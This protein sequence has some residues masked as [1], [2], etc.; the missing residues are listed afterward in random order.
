MNRSPRKTGISGD[1]GLFFCMRPMLKSMS[2]LHGQEG[3]TY[4]AFPSNVMRREL[5]IMAASFVKSTY[6]SK[7]YVPQE[8]DRT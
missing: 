5:Q 2:C 7:D 4:V 8:S 1:L 3:S 6:T